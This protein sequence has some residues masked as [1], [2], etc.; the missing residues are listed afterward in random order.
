M[1][2][3]RAAERCLGIAGTSVPGRRMDAERVGRVFHRRHVPAELTMGHQYRKHLQVAQLSRPGQQ[4]RDQ[5]H[6]QSGD[7]G[8]RVASGI[9]AHTRN[10]P[11]TTGLTSE[12]EPLRASGRRGTVSRLMRRR[13]WS[14][15][16]P[17]CLRGQLLAQAGGPPGQD[18]ARLAAGAARLPEWVCMGDGA[19][20]RNRGPEAAR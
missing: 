11:G 8:P 6:T 9:C 15:S 5:Q 7:P 4:V 16:S 3:D 20:P 2:V 17:G 12:Y 1:D 10:R 13:P 14:S 19:H 18:L